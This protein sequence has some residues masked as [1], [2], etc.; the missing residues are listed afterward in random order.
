MYLPEKS[1]MSSQEPL[2]QGPFAQFDRLSI[3]TDF[4]L[5]RVTCDFE[6]AFEISHEISPQFYRLV[7]HVFEVLCQL[8]LD[9]LCGGSGVSNRSFHRC[10]RCEISGAGE[11]TCHIP[12]V[13]PLKDRER[14]RYFPDCEH[15]PIASGEV[16]TYDADEHRMQQ[17]CSR[18]SPAS[19]AWLEAP[20]HWDRHP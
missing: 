2:P 1:L 16:S 4:F 13:A 20:W 6:A 10:A 18:G 7:V 3:R 11:N 8:H 17:H 5:C 9:Y 14:A 12:K 19:F 15:I